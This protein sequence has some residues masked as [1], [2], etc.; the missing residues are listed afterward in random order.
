MKKKYSNEFKAKVALDSIRGGKKLSEIAAFYKV[1][2]SIVIHW[3][4]Q[5][6]ENAPDIFE[7]STTLCIL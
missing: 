2:P 6:I 5:L 7:K 4:K 1:Y 3:R